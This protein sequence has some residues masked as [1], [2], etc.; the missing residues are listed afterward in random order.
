MLLRNGSIAMQR[1]WKRVMFARNPAGSAIEY[2]RSARM[3]SP[4][5]AV[6]NRLKASAVSPSSES[7]AA[8]N[9]SARS[10]DRSV[11][12]PGFS[13]DE[14]T[15]YL[16]FLGFLGQPA[17]G[18]PSRSR[19]RDV[20]RRARSAAAEIEEPLPAVRRRL[21]PPPP[22]RSRSRSRRSRRC[23]SWERE[24]Q[25]RRARRPSRRACRGSP[26][27]LGSLATARDRRP[28]RDGP[29]RAERP[30]GTSVGPP[31]RCG[32]TRRSCQGASAPGAR[33]PCGERRPSAASRAAE[34]GEEGPPEAGAARGP[35]R[36]AT[37]RACGT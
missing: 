4:S 17:H 9:T 26:R 37:R 35:E 10:V 13:P 5:P 8:S 12:V 1:A 27:R 14:L 30:Y 2:E 23:R 36:S 18:T 6:S 32:R 15:A 7:P 22:R 31:P 19:A 21:R 34:E 16:L 28:G 11:D 3:T 33:V 25:R 24:Q 20:A 29:C